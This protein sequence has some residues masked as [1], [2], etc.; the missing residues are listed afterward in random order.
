VLAADTR[1][2][3]L[4]NELRERRI[5]SGV[6]QG[7]LFKVCRDEQFTS[8]F[9]SS[10]ASG[11]LSRALCFSIRKRH[12]S[13]CAKFHTSRMAK[14]SNSSLSFGRRWEFWYVVCSRR[15]AWSSVLPLVCQ[16]N[17]TGIYDQIAAEINNRR[18]LSWKEKSKCVATLGEM[19]LEPNTKRRLDVF[20]LLWQNDE[21]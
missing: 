10:T 11:I 17:R 1:L 18:R 12:C 5:C 4:T 15:K 21:G 8:Y 6:G 16:V 9:F 7:R 19:L 13:G 2:L 3:K 20:W 14:V